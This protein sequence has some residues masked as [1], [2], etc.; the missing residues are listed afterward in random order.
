MKEKN[1]RKRKQKLQVAVESR[2][3]KRSEKKRLSLLKKVE[4]LKP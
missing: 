2:T 3:Y 4:W 1:E